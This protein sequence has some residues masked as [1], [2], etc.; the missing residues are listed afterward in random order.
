M[1]YSFQ[2]PLREE[3]PPLSEPEAV[4]R[5]GLAGPRMV[6]GLR[7]RR[8]KAIESP[9]CIVQLIPRNAGMS[10]VSVIVRNKKGE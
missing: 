10:Q 6:E 5:V 3:A 9:G 1:V 2:S 8:V 7:L 4:S